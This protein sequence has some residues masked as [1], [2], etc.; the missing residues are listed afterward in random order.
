MSMQSVN[1]DTFSTP[2]EKALIPELEQD[3]AQDKPLMLLNEV[4]LEV[5][6]KIDLIDAIVQAPSRAARRKAIKEAAEKLG[7][8]PRTIQRLLII[9]NS[10]ILNE[11]LDLYEFVEEKRKTH[12]PQVVGRVRGIF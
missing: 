3:Q 11:R 6:Q 4:S 12:I 8:S 5:Q 1:F 9:D 10:S 2:Q 7:K